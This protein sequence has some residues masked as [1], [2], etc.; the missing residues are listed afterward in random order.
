MMAGAAGVAVLCGTLG[1]GLAGS[2]SA[3]VTHSVTEV[4]AAANHNPGQPTIRRGAHGTAV[5][6]LQRALRRTGNH[7]VVVDGNF[8]P[9]T[10][11]AVKSF[12]RSAGL[13]AD[14]IV[15]AATWKALPNGAPM[16][17]LRQGSSGGAVRQL[18]TVLS[19]G[20][21]GQWGT[22]PG[23]SDGIF[24]PRTRASLE[25]FQRWA[26][27]PVTGTVGDPT[28]AASLH[29]AGA[30]LESAVGLQFVRG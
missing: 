2:A 28:W 11:T 14:G 27:V 21:A 17:Y 5:R 25:A 16:P 6:R 24:G 20:A 8:N 26:H 13:R 7:N 18:Q 15:G 19:N 4:T 3:T 23:S 9:Q 30:T 10:E 29:A 12:Q 1:A 22:T